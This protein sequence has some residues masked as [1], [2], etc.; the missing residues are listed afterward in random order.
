MV[1]KTALIS[2]SVDWNVF[3]MFLIN[4]AEGVS[5]TNL[6]ANLVQIN[7]A[8]DG[9]FCQHGQHINSFLVSTV[10]RKVFI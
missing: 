7:F 1:R 8:V 2:P 6:V 10:G 5:L 9:C 4:D 3:T